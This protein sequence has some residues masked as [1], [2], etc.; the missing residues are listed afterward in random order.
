MSEVRGIDGNKQ[1]KGN[2]V[3]DEERREAL[4]K[5]GIY[6]AYTAPAMIALLLPKKCLATSGDCEIPPCTEQP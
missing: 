3:I 5:L 1:L 4:K 2:I 6:A